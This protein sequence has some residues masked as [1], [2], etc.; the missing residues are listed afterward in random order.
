MKLKSIVLLLTALI[1]VLGLVGCNTQ[2]K[3]DAADAER[4]AIIE[5][6]ING[7]FNEEKTDIILNLKQEQINDAEEQLALEKDHK[8]SEANL[9]RID[10][11]LMYLDLAIDM[12]AFEL[13][14]DQLFDQA[15]G[16][17]KTAEIDNVEENLMFYER[18]NVFY[19]RQLVKL[20]DA[21]EQLFAI[22][23][24]REQVQ[25]LF[26]DGE[27]NSD[28]TREQET[29]MRELI[30]TLKSGDAKRELEASLVKVA[31]LL[32]NQERAVA[33]AQ[34][35]QAEAVEKRREAEATQAEVDALAKEQAAIDAA[36]QEKTDEIEDNKKE[37][38]E[39]ETK[40]TIPVD[41]MVE[42]EIDLTQPEEEEE[43]VEEEEEEEEV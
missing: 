8:F 36:K 17:V 4:L 15:G 28:V 31:A 24:V 22:E 33:S 29:E 14:V 16:L 37:E 13:E 2:E 43:K 27:V 21:K 42:G 18:E 39:T 6:K 41:D 3:K 40:P 25:T 5:E 9:K 11:I 38:P 30:A 32:S 12:V 19:D 23:E 34:R 10:S 26:N 1:V 7:L 20:I 35:E